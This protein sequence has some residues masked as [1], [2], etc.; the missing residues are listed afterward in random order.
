M[1][2]C[3]R[4]FLAV[5]LKLSHLLAR[6]PFLAKT[7]FFL[8]FF[9]G[10]FFDGFL[11]PLLVAKGCPKGV[12]LRHFFSLLGYLFGYPILASFFDSFW[13]ARGREKA[14]FSM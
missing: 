11:V 1:V 2:V 4:S 9:G 14:V 7:G 12:V 10:R 3:S 8:V 6:F 5:S 13:A